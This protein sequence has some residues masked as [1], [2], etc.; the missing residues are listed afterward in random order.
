MVVVAAEPGPGPWTIVVLEPVPSPGCVVVVELGAVE[1]EVGPDVP[2]GPAVVVVTAGLVVVV[3]VVAG[4]CTVEVVT[5]GTVAP[6][7]KTPPLVGI[8]VGAGAAGG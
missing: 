6:G 3:V 5:D 7:K 8:P 2:V 4:V 1:P